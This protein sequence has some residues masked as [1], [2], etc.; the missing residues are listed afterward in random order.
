M[1]SR[2]P[3]TI[4]RVESEDLPEVA[5]AF[6]IGTI[7][8]TDF[9]PSGLMNLNWRVAGS[10]ATAAVK[11]LV[12]VDRQQAARSLDL[13]GFLADTGI[14]VPSP[15]ATAAGEPVVAVGDGYYCAVPWVDGEH[16]PG[17]DLSTAQAAQLGSVLGRIH[18]ALGR[19]AAKAGLEPPIGDLVAKVSDPEAVD[20]S[21]HRFLDVIAALP[22]REP[23][24]ADAADTLH[25][26]RELL[27]RHRAQRPATDRPLVPAG[28]THGDFQPLNLLWNENTV[29]AV[30][31]WDRVAF[32]PYGE[33]IVRS[34]NYLFPAA[35]GR[36]LDLERIAAFVTAYRT[37]VPQ[38]TRADGDDAVERMWW[39]RLTDLWHL[40]FRYDRGDTS[41]DH[42]YGASCL[43]L[44][45][46]T[47]RRELVRE[48]FAAGGLGEAG[49]FFFLE[50]ALPR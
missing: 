9:L 15:L 8:R 3:E 41:C 42:L 43:V 19:A 47:E 17:R 29:A 23:F 2:D 36:A 39:R 30:L 7:E 40:E 20:G 22:E 46:W 18:R 10:R 33:E 4:K 35:D 1:A 28:W 12:D 5:A 24:D 44:E 32:R 21:M 34:A 37:E 26:R 31:D 25:R 27:A 50:G 45:W 38:F 48:A 13:L 14:P 49:E 16:I 6:G 11:R